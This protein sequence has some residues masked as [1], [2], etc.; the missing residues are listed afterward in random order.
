MQNASSAANINVMQQTA[1]KLFH[2]GVTAEGQALQWKYLLQAENKI[3]DVINDG[4]PDIPNPITNAREA[5]IA[6]REKDR[7]MISQKSNIKQKG[8]NIDRGYMWNLPTD[9]HHPRSK[10]LAIHKARNKRPTSKPKSKHPRTKRR[11]AF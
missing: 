11:G 10:V 7:Q 2:E 4:L 8:P 5:Y 1:N 6:S 3:K 9:S